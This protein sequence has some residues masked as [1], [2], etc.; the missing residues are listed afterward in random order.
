MQFRCFAWRIVALRSMS[1]HCCRVAL[2]WDEGLFGES[3]SLKEV[4]LA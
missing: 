3:A 1:W 2:C 4:G